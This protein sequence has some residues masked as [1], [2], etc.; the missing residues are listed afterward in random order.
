MAPQDVD[1]NGRGWHGQ[2]Q[3]GVAQQDDD[4]EGRHEEEGRV[5]KGLHD[6]GKGIHSKGRRQQGA[7]KSR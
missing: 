4:G 5:D 3:Q 7:S 1:N 6:D 2:C